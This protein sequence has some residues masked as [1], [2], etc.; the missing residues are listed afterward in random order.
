MAIEE[1]LAAMVLANP[2]SSIC[3]KGEK[4]HLA[5]ATPQRDI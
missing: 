4:L 3:R 1:V 2:K 5:L